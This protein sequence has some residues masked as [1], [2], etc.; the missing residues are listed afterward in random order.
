MVFPAQKSDAFRYYRIGVRMTVGLWRSSSRGGT[1]SDRQLPPI[2]NNCISSYRKIVFL[3]SENCIFSYRK[4]V[5][6]LSENCISP[7]RKLYFL[8]SKHLYFTCI[9]QFFFILLSPTL[10]S[11]F[12]K[13]VSSSCL[14]L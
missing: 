14:E 10:L 1:F 7:V 5:F 6:L 11:H 8:I 3:L 12:G 13:I 4:I 2:S 9:V